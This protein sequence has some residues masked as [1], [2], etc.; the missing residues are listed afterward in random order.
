MVDLED[1]PSWFVSRPES[2]APV[3]VLTTTYLGAW[4]DPP[5]A[6]Q[7]HNMSFL[8]PMTGNGLY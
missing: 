5:R 7:C 4:D 6:K 1:H 2:G 3:T 8:P